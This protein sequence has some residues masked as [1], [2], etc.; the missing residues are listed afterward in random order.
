MNGL[1][2]EDSQLASLAQL[3]MTRM[4]DVLRGDTNCLLS[5][6]NG[7]GHGVLEL[8]QLKVCGRQERADKSDR[9]S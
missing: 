9:L 1:F 5:A 3:L 4:S 8:V 7:H 6:G 2:P